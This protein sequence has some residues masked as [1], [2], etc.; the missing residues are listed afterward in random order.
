MTK[1]GSKLL[2][3]VR[4]R[5]GHHKARALRLETGNFSWGSEAIARKT[6]ILNV[7]YN[8]SSNELVRTNTLVKGCIVQVDATPYRQWYLQHYGV[9]L[10]KKKAGEEDEEIKRSKAAEKKLEERNKNRVLEEA[11]A[12]MMEKGRVLAR[13]SSRP[14]QCGRCDGYLLEGEELVFYSRQLQKKKKSGK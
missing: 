7:V 3:D 12:D 5:G 4:V 13:V 9:A 2:R 14:G 8:A 6:R 10:G 1:I 11:I